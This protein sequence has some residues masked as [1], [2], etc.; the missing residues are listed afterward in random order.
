MIERK[1]ISAPRVL[2]LS[3]LSISVPRGARLRDIPNT[4]KWKN[5]LLPYYFSIK[6]SGGKEKEGCKK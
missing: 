4:H 6:L 2:G 5:R 1:K 3:D